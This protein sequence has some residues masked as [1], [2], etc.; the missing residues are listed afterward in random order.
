VQRVKGKTCKEQEHL[1]ELASSQN[2]PLYL[3]F[4][5]D[6]PLILPYAYF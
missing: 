1:H 5:F 3:V 2:M 6:K 4:S